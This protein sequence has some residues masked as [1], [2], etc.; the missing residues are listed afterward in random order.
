MGQG[1]RP[2]PTPPHGVTFTHH[3]HALVPEVCNPSY[4]SRPTVAGQ[5]PIAGR[6]TA[7]APGR[8]VHLVWYSDYLSCT[9]CTVCCLPLLVGLLPRVLLCCLV[10]GVVPACLPG[11]CCR[12]AV[13]LYCSVACRCAGHRQH[14]LSG[15]SSLPIPEPD[16]LGTRKIRVEFGL[17][18]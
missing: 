16:I 5:P 3:A 14:K 10:R 17:T 1:A 15:S 6:P 7:Q 13:L 12:C 9:S 4:S 8:S 11:A 18:C 2:R